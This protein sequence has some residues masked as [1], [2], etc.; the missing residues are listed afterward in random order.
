[1]R[2]QRNQ[3]CKARAVRGFIALMNTAI[4]SGRS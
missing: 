1:M 4:S 2:M 3:E